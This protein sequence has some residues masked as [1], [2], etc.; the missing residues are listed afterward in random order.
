[1]VNRNI[2]NEAM[3]K[4]FSLPNF[5]YFLFKHFHVATHAHTRINRIEICY[6]YR[7]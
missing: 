4:A 3:S 6:I 2:N 5:S 1:M 7:I